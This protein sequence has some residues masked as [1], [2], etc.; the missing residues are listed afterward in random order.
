MLIRPT[1]AGRA[2]WNKYIFEG[3][4]RDQRLLRALSHEE[5]VQLNALLR[6]VLLDLES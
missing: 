6:K 2:L 1:A 5:L 4:A 3:M